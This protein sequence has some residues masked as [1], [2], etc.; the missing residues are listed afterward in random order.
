[1]TTEEREEEEREIE[2]LFRPYEMVEAEEMLATIQTFDP[3]GVAARDLRESILI[4]LSRKGL[5]D[6]LPSALVEEHFDG[7]HQPPL[8]RDRQGQ[9]NHPPG[10]PGRGRRR[11][12][13]WIRSRG[14]GIPP[15]PSDTSF[16]ISSSRRSTGS[17]WSLPTTRVCRGSAS[18]GPT[19]R[20]PGTRGSSPVRTRI[21]SPPS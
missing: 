12:P 11:S 18:P 19:V 6:S 14:T 2:A 3:P 1:M 17:T 13:S 7:P 15:I 8:G 4:Q 9:G 16:R 21:S 10:G 20:W 5:A